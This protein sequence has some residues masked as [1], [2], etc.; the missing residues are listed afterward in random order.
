MVFVTKI[1]FKSPHWDLFLTITERVDNINI[2]QNQN[3]FM[4]FH[5]VSIPIMPTE[6]AKSSNK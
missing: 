1:L 3:I 5:S 4:H 6:R 2:Q